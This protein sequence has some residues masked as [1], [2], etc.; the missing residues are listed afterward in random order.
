MLVSDGL[1]VGNTF[2]MSYEYHITV[3]TDEPIGQFFE[4]S[5]EY[6]LETPEEVED[7]PNSVSVDVERKQ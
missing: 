6:W 5:I 3:E 1:V 4:E 7:S 2:N